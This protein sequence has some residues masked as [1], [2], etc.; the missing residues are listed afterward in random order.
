MRAL[1]RIFKL[2]DLDNDGFLSDNVIKYLQV[3]AF[4][5]PLDKINLIEL[6]QLID[7]NCV[8][9]LCHDCS[10]ESGFV[11]SNNLFIQQGRIETTWTILRSFGYA[12]DLSLRSDLVQPQFTLQSGCSVEL[13][14]VGIQFL[15][16]LFH[17]HDKDHDGA[18][19]TPKSRWTCSTCV[20]TPTLEAWTFCTVT[21]PTPKTGS[22]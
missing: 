3:K 6:K 13:L 9:G 5:A 19:S 14:S 12:D 4:G 15:T 10:T 1:H 11:Y 21:Q 22:T 18:L 8:D 7:Y 2:C 16:S 20:P 17:K